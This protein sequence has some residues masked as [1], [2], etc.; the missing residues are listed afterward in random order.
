MIR[1]G[2][3][4]GGT[5]TD[6]T[7]LDTEAETFHIL[8][9][10]SST[11]DQSISVAAGVRQVLTDLERES[12]AVSYLGHGTTAATNALLEMRGAR[13]A[14]VTTAGQ[15]PTV[16]KNIPTSQTRAPIQPSTGLVPTLFMPT[17][18]GVAT[19]PARIRANTMAGRSRMT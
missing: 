12:D 14:L 7:A 19:S 16:S 5:F 4:V 8:K 15:S 17:I 9:L 1:I 2:V 3:D 18:T 11:E 13:S 10:P 6:V